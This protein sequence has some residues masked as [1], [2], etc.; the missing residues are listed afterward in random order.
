MQK[1]VI[2]A[3]LH[4]QAALVHQDHMVSSHGQIQIV[5]NADHRGLLLGELLDGLQPIGLVR[6]IHIG[7]WFVHQKNGGLHRQGSAQQNPLALTARQLQQTSVLQMAQLKAVHPRLND[8]LVLRTCPR[9]HRL[10]R[11]A[12]QHQHILHGQIIGAGLL[13]T[14]PSHALGSVF[15]R[16]RPQGFA[17]NSQFPRAGN[18]ACQRFEQGG[19]ASTIGSYHAGPLTRFNRQLHRVQH[20]RFVNT[21]LQVF[22]FYR[23]G[24][25]H[26]AFA[27]GECKRQSK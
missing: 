6:N 7:N 11:Q 3:G 18:Q 23:K 21:D 13:L 26:M 1:R 8:G 27:E 4:H 16:H 15:V 9:P 25:H 14:Q 2:W 22:R 17:L 24:L 19:L 10:M 20:L 12:A 5:Q